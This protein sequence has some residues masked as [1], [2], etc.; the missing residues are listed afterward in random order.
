MHMWKEEYRERILIVGEKEIR[1]QGPICG[2]AF[3]D[4]KQ[5]T[6]QTGPMGWNW[7]DFLCCGCRDCGHILWF[8]DDAV[9]HFAKEAEPTALERFEMEFAGYSEK[10]LL[11]IV[12]SD[13]YTDDARTAARNLLRKRQSPLMR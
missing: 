4:C 9:Q 5:R 3:F 1:L 6:I 10:K 2:G 8:S 13:Q 12:D 7:E 11:K